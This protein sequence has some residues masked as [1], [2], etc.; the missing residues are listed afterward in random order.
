MYFG[1]N[2]LVLIGLSLAVELCFVKGD[3]KFQCDIGYEK[4]LLLEVQ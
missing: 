2:N 1:I 4:V 3:R